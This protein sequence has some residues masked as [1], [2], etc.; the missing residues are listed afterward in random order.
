MLNF[1]SFHIQNHSFIVG[2]N[3]GYMGEIGKDAPLTLLAECKKSISRSC[4]EL[5]HCIVCFCLQYSGL[6]QYED[7]EISLPNL[8]IA[9]DRGMYC[10][11]LSHL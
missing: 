2:I 6:S 5:W 10:R 4:L 3:V 9:K 11:A 1:Q 7:D 8:T